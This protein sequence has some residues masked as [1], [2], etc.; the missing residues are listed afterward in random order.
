MGDNE[1][2]VTVKH[3][4]EVTRNSRRC[5]RIVTLTAAACLTPGMVRCKHPLCVEQECTPD[6][7]H[8][9]ARVA[10]HSLAPPSC[11]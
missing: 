6:E 5:V 1:I 10:G 9:A 7:G 3:C 2:Q 8:S 11:V 4:S